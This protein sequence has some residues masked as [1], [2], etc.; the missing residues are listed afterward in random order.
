MYRVSAEKPQHKV[1][2][3]AF[4]VDVLLYL[5][6]WE[7]FT[8]KMLFSTLAL[9]SWYLSTLALEFSTFQLP[10]E[11]FSEQNPRPR[12]RWNSQDMSVLV[13]SV[14][15]MIVQVLTQCF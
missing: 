6:F 12:L 13:T 4:G 11:C 8:L 9:E 10:R 7:H 5:L 3:E 14:K 15:H 1:I 2:L